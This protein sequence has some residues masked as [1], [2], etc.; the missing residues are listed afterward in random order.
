MKPA[1]HQQF[2]SN[3]DKKKDCFYFRFQTCILSLKLDRKRVIGE[4]DQRQR[5]PEGRSGPPHPQQ[6]CIN[7]ESATRWRCFI[8]LSALTPA[9]LRLRDPPLLRNYAESHRLWFRNHQRAEPSRC[10]Q[11]RG[12]G[13][14]RKEEKGKKTKGIIDW[15][16]CRCCWRS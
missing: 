2:P 15:I 8:S 6:L 1:S 9:K 3:K 7:M 13:G 10:A 5:Q 16:L 11:S 14:R 12:W 4:N